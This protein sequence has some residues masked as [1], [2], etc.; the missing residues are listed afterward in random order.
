MTRIRIETTKLTLL[1]F[2]L[3]LVLAWFCYRPALSGA[4][5]LDDIPNLGGLAQIEDVET[6]SN[7]ILSGA[8]GLTGRPLAL[9]TFAFQADQ[10]E[11]GPRA[12]LKVNVLI[13]L[14]NALLLAWCLWQLALLMGVQRERALIVATSAAGLWMLLPVLA[15]S[16]LLV[17]QRMTTLSALF[18]LLG[19]GGYLAVRRNV[20]RTPRRSLIAMAAL[21]A[22]STLLAA[23][24]KESGFLLPMFVLVLE[25][26]ILMRPE[27]IDERDWRIWKIVVLVLPSSPRERRSP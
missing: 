19:L 3:V 26:T 20:D 18:I 2:F 21:L 12:F 1:G 7:Y 23:L 13:H 9:L 4:F 25:A 24:A 8:R 15:T 10:F 11:N 17:V 16:S 27:R 5:Q 22:V 14:L 6:A